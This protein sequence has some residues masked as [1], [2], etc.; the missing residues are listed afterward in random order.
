MAT[1][2]PTIERKV[3]QEQTNQSS[4]KAYGRLSGRDENAVL[5]EEQ[6]AMQFNARIGENYKRLINPDYTKP[7][8]FATVDSYGYANNSFFE[9]V[10]EHA[11]VTE[12]IFH[13]DSVYNAPKK[14]FADIPVASATTYAEPVAPVQ[15][16]AQ[17]YAPIEEPT[18]APIDEQSFATEDKTL[19]EVDLMPSSTTIQYQNNL[20]KDEQ[21]SESKKSYKMSSKGKVMMLIYSLAVVVILALIIINT[22]VL[23]TLDGNVATQREALSSVKTEYVR[24]QEEIDTLTSAESIISRA[25]KDLGMVVGD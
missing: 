5:T 3:E 8:Q 17:I 7:E 21:Q 22:S 19:E 4:L 6:K 2:F 13:A 24:V 18:F 10:F 20:Y 9:P 14:S 16:Q 1:L 23:N 25:E 11:R 12:D 15:E